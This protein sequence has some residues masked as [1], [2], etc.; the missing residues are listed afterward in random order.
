M[1]KTILEFITINHFQISLT[2]FLWQKKCGFLPEMYTER[3][4]NCSGPFLLMSSCIIS[5]IRR[6]DSLVKREL[7]FYVIC[8]SHV[9]REIALIL[10]FFYSFFILAF[11]FCRFFGFRLWFWTCFIFQH[12]SQWSWCN[13]VFIQRFILQIS[14]YSVCFSLG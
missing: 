4:W 9:F 8:C 13:C 14:F 11:D 1:Y 10:S 2:L 5:Y 6:A 7:T 12:W 3:S